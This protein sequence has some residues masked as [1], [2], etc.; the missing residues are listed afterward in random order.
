MTV[1]AVYVDAWAAVTLDA[2]DGTP[3]RFGACLDDSVIPAAHRRR[4]GTFG[5]MA[6]SCGLS[7]AATD[8]S[9]LVFCSRY[10]DVDLAHKLVTEVVAGG[11]LSP[12][13]FSLSVHNA[14]PG[15]MDLVRGSRAGH[16]AIAAGSQSLS[17]GLAEAWAKLVERPDD[18]IAFVYADCALPA[19]YQQFS[20]MKLGGTAVA[21]TLSARK[22]VSTF[23]RFILE[24]ASPANMLDDPGSEELAGLLMQILGSVAGDASIRW[25]SRGLHWLFAAGADATD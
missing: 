5:R 2:K 24:R 16:T 9:D 20:E 11:L 13:A 25:R 6:V 7:I 23:G 3:Q 22:P 12:A 18:K 1:S 21:L 19:I 17:A 4:L 8:S 14:V 15:V 10:G